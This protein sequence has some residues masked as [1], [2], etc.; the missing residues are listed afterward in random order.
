MFS[1]SVKARLL[2][3]SLGVAVVSGA[4]AWAWGAAPKW[5]VS[6]TRTKAEIRLDWSEQVKVDVDIRDREIVLRFDKPLGDPK[7]DS[8]PQRLPSWVSNVLYGYDSL[9]I[10]M[11]RETKTQVF[12]DTTPNHSSLR[13]VMEAEPVPVEQQQAADPEEARQNYR[14]NFY[15][16]RTLMETGGELEARAVLRDLMESDPRPTNAMELLAQTEERLGRWQTALSLY[17]RAL[18]LDPNKPDTIRY[19][20]AILR[21]NGGFV[22][23]EFVFRDVTNADQQYIN[24]TSGRA[25][26]NDRTTVGIAVDTRGVDT[27]LI[28]RVDGRLDNL[29]VV[30]SRQELWG[31]YDWDTFQQTRAAVLGGPAGAGFSI[32]HTIGQP[33]ARTR[34]SVTYN[35]S[36]FDYVEGILDKGNRS[37]VAIRHERRLTNFSDFFDPITLTLAVNANRYGVRNDNNVG[38]TVGGE[39]GLR[40]VFNQEGPLASV[41]YTYES[42]YILDKETRIGVDGATFNPLPLRSRELHIGDVQLE[43][44]LTDYLRYSIVLGYIH[45]RLNSG[46]PLLSGALFYEP[47]TN[48]ELGLRAARTVNSV[49][50]TDQT[51]DIFGVSGLVRF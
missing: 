13:I 46:G 36:D 20:A 5:E 32:A 15:R 38:N 4:G 41:G 22:R 40:W 45:D 3:A 8:L 19:R 50:G 28:R 16:A 44:A 37:R 43:D 21:E 47:I 35:E 31:T 42:E 10:T 23:N 49:R 2:A 29:S 11:P 14:I 51:V 9:V 6:S 33:R 17:D 34:V 30:R 24:L 12:P 26:V 27:G 48:V 39:V 7:I 25:L 18:E 1:R